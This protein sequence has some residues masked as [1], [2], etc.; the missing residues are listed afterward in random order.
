MVAENLALALEDSLS[1]TYLALADWVHR[2]KPPGKTLVLGVNGAQGS[3]KSTLCVFLKLILRE[4]YGY[5]VAGFSIDDLYKTRAE[6]QR[7]AAEIH[8]L[9]ATRG[10]PGSHDV[11]LGL[12]TLRALRSPLSSTTA[13]PAFDK[14]ND[15]RRPLAEWLLFDGPADVIVFEGWCMGTR[16]QACCAL[17]EPVNELERR[18]DRFGVWRRHVNRQLETDYAQLFAALDKLVFIQVPGME[19]VIRWR[20]A[21]EEK[22]A[23]TRAGRGLM[24]QTALRR[25]IMH[26]ERLTRHNLDEMP[27][28]AD[29]ILCLNEHHQFTPLIEPT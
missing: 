9:F 13:L 10:V 14:A 23:A 20:G 6:R 21:Q 2:Q 4:A 18:E 1:R 26:Y 7:M 24:D 12:Q 3:G 29:L 17:F 5:N 19:C 27:G 16:P 15:D 11:A 8:P 25:F 28:R 22:L